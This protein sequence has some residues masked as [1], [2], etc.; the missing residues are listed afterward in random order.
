MAEGG[1]ASLLPPC[2]PIPPNNLTG[3][4]STPPPP[5]F[6]S[7]PPAEGERSAAAG[8][9]PIAVP[10]RPHSLAHTP[11]HG[12]TS[13]AVSTGTPAGG[14]GGILTPAARSAAPGLQCKPLSY[15]LTGAAGAPT[16][17]ATTTPA[18]E[19]GSSEDAACPLADT[20][21]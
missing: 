4:A 16:E 6:S 10:A 19:K 14:W 18:Q 21:P 2:S 13:A 8:A 17:W 15:D 5:S 11:P 7:P 3:G 9:L 20:V 12:P 1:E